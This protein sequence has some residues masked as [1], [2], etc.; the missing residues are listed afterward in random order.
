[1]SP[2]GAGI[3]ASLSCGSWTFGFYKFSRY[4]EQESKSRNC[5]SKYHLKA[6]NPKECNCKE[7]A[8]WLELKV[9]FPVIF[10]KKDWIFRYLLRWRR[11][12][13]RNLYGIT[14][15]KITAS[16]V[17]ILKFEELYKFHIDFNGKAVL[18]IKTSYFIS[19]KVSTH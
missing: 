2:V 8:K 3:I 18:E 14:K 19:I 4:K 9:T 16:N 12:I 6:G 7:G 1:M 11:Y 13:C 15:R 10:G 17:Y 5:L